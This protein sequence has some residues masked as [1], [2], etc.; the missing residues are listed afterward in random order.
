[1][2]PSFIVSTSGISL[3][4]G[5]SSTPGS[6]PM[7]VMIGGRGISFGSGRSALAAGASAPVTFAPMIANEARKNSMRDG[8]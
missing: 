2:V 8:L 7:E 4:T 6:V 3:R 1:M 5:N